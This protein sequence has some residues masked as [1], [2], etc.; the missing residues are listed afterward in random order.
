[1]KKLLLVIMLGLAVMVSTM[2]ADTIFEKYKMKDVTYFLD[3]NTM[4]CDIIYESYMVS[5][6]F[7][8]LDDPSAKVKLHRG[9]ALVIKFSGY[10]YYFF[11][12]Y[13]LCMETVK[14]FK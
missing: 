7:A 5:D 13:E 2:N 11:D 9:G 1:M 14:R 8:M 4:S 10:S 6:I 3:G 12:N